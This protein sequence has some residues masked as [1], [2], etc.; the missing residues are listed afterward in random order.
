MMGVWI[1]FFEL[2]LMGWVSWL[3]SLVS[4]RSKRAENEKLITV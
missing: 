2:V 4:T 3:I 1:S